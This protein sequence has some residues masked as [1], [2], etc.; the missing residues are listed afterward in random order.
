MSDQSF[1]RIGHGGK[2]LPIM[3]S[4]MDRTID[5]GNCRTRLLLPRPTV[6]TP[7]RPVE[8]I[9]RSVRRKK[10]LVLCFRVGPRLRIVCYLTSSF[11]DTEKMAALSIEVACMSMLRR[12]SRFLPMARGRQHKCPASLCKHKIFSPGKKQLFVLECTRYQSTAIGNDIQVPTVPETHLQSSPN[13][14]VLL[15]P[16]FVDVPLTVTEAVEQS[17]TDLGLGGHTPVGLI[18]NFLEYLHLGIGMPWWGAIMTGTL[19][20]RILVFPLI[21]KGQREAAKLNNHM[22]QI[23]AITTRMNEAKHS[24][25]KF[26]FSKAY[27]D[28]SLYQKKHDVNPLRGFIVPLVQAPIFISFFV[29][30]RQ[31]SYLPV[32]SF[33]NGGL[34]WFTDL[35]A[36]DPF[37]ILP[38]VVTGSMWAVLELGAE[39]GVD[40]PNLKV[41]KTVFRV[42]PLVILP[43]TI[44]FPTAVFTYWVTSNIF[45]IAQ[46]G[47]LKIPAV[48]KKLGIPE[49]IKHDPASLPQ[50]EGFMKSLKSGWKNAQVAQ[51]LEERE[52]RIKNH[53]DL[54][55]KGP[56]RP[57]FSQNPLQQKESVPV[58][59]S[60]SKSKPWKDTI[61]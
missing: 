28:L 2:H 24:G 33:Q 20:A 36:S 26:E 15:P 32:P 25:N 51:Q 13:P 31:M 5:H 52:R 7:G 40:N 23:S 29:A 34:W 14:D 9:E 56:L 10:S 60:K 39:S 18:Q 4:S 12:G 19:L 38:L 35:T 8:S 17:I 11:R 37:Y 54:A 57:T 16:P 27:S 22:P 47:F 58:S 55:A 1:I 53:L 50:Q 61:G 48:R 44:N 59:P 6:L 30:L 46:V 21:V 41:M 42:M 45:S 49:R 43:L 3:W